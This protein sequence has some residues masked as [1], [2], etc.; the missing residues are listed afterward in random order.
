MTN[1][2][3]LN[4]EYKKLVK[5]LNLGSLGIS[6]KELLAHPLLQ[7]D[8]LKEAIPG[9]IRKAEHFLNFMRRIIVY[10]K[11]ELNTKEVKIQ[12]PLKL[13]Y[14]LQAQHFVDQRSLKFAHERLHSLL[15][16]LEI[17]SIDI[18]SPLSIVADFAT[19]I[20]TYFKGFTVIIEPYPE[21]LI[22]DPLLQF[23]CLDASIATKPLFEKYKNVILTSGTISPIDI[24]PKI[25]NFQPK[26]SRAIKI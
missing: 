21:E 24:Y 9:S 2:E 26:I 7:S 1:S 8:T 18:Y 10:L 20:S 3:K 13:V 15:N 17:V 6:E 16:T 23:Y 14:N 22:Y 11:Q 19:L 25:L 5:G 12:T 4:D